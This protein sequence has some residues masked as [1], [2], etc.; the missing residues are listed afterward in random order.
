MPRKSNKEKID[1]ARGLYIRGKLNQ[2]EIAAQL[3][4]REATISTW[5]RKENWKQLRT[6]QRITREEQIA[7]LYGQLDRMMGD[8]EAREAEP[9]AT[10]GEADAISKIT[11][12]ISKLESESGLAA[13]V[14]VFIG[15]AQWLSKRDA[16]AARKFSQL[17]DQY[18]KSLVQ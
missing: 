7:R 18:I 15:F 14:Q 13:T 11:Q 8:I 9:Y 17:Q 16:D 2:K 3:G 5:A 10:P 1:L 12:A 4:V 6:A